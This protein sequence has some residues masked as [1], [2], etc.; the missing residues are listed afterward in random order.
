MPTHQG[1]MCVSVYSNQIGGAFLASHC[2]DALRQE[3]Y[4]TTHL[5][6]HQRA[7]R[8]GTLTV[9]WDSL[10]LGLLNVVRATR[11]TARTSAKVSES[12]VQLSVG[13]IK[14]GELTKAFLKNETT[15]V[16]KKLTCIFVFN[17]V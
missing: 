7:R 12:D 10:H 1:L 8:I 13:S 9:T 14:F 4:S 17:L 2:Q 5:P 3:A 15:S 16:K 11:R 6:L